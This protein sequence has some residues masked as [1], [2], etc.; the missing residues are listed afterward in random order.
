[1][2]ENRGAGRVDELAADDRRGIERLVAGWL[3]DD[4]V[5]GAALAVVDGDDVTYADGFGARDLEDNAPATPETLF[6]V[7]S[8]TKSFTA[9]A[10]V[11]LAEAGALSLEDPVDDY[12]PHLADAPGDPVTLADL[13]THTSGLPSDGSA[14]PLIT[15]PLGLG[16]VEVPLS[17][18]GDF[19]RHVQ[20]AADGRVTDRETFFYYNSG[21][22]MLGLVVEAVTG[23][24][25]AEYV[26]DE[27]LAPLGMDRST[28]DRAAFEAEADRMTPYVEEEGSSREAAF[29]FDEFVHAP[30][31]LVSSVT[32]MA[33]WVRLFLGEGTVDGET[34]VAPERVA[35]MR[36]P[37]GTF[38]T[39]V[40]GT[41]VGYGYGLMVEELLGD[42]L[43]GH[44]GSVAVSNAWFG[45]LED[46]ELG[47]AVACG[48]GP[49][50]HPT[51]VGQAVLALL[52][53]EDP[54]DV[55]PYYR[56]QAAL[57]AATGEYAGHRGITTATVERVGGS[58]RL[59]VESGPGGQ[60]HLL[61][62]ERV[63]PDLLV[64]TT[65][66][67]GGMQ[68]PARFELDGGT[69]SLFLERLRL[70]QSG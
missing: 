18:R 22:T 41:E 35:S 21:Y 64:C 47:V 16:H 67:V 66:T 51:D 65:T 57:A 20:D 19:R 42:R 1:M 48:A 3:S 58:L 63:E 8:C 55:V 9:A 12:L 14:G 7:G 33:E 68:R 6:G 49:E 25:Y 43:V 61:V 50:A 46:A 28:F 34:V 52:Q 24:P 30:G 26:A 4:R 62:P 2:T 15:R 38:G 37:V 53:G 40:D 54:E 5:P 27:L 56:L 13:L 70:E 10:V 69:V 45:Y 17:S 59:S 44:G 29:P 32:E 60:E 31:G 11:Q 39:H 23:R 36:A